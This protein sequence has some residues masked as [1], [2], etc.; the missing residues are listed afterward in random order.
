MNATIVKQ[1]SSTRLSPAELRGRWLRMLDDPV[2]ADVPGKLELTEKGTIEL[3]LASTRHGILQAFVAG[4]MQRLRSDGTAMTECGIETDIGIRVPDVAWASSEFMRR[5]G[6]ATPLP[7]APELC[8]E[9]LSP[10]NS[11]PE[12]EQKTAAYLAAGAIEV[13]L[14]FFEAYREISSCSNCGDF[15]A[16]RA[17][18]RFRRA[19][20]GKSEY[21]HT[22]N[23]SGLA[24]GRTLIAILENGQRRDG[25]I[26]IPGALQPYFGAAEIR[27][28]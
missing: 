25:S 12:I 10:T 28:A 20:G 6:T 26:A 8:V 2:L 19:Q 11:R 5:H 17:A 16:R 27:P 3:S 22:L 15:Q 18:I 7:R 14:P 24:V 4:E 21:A 13:W 9:V 1:H 23:G